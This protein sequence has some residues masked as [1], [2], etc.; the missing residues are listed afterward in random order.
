VKSLTKVAVLL[1][2]VVLPASADT[3]AGRFNM[4]FGAAVVGLGEIDWTPA[5]NP[6]LDLVP[7]FGAFTMNPLSGR[8][9]VFLD[10]VLNTLP[11]GG[12]IGDL[13]QNPLDANYVPVGVPIIRPNFITLAEKPTLNFILDLLFPGDIIGGSPSAFV[14]A[15]SGPNVSATISL[16]GTALDIGSG[17]PITVWTASISTQYNNTTVPDLIAFALAGG[18]LPDNAWS[19]TLD[20]VPEP[21]SLAL[22]LGLGLGAICIQG[23]RLKASRGRPQ[24]EKV[25]L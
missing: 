2:S 11:N 22:M 25:A 4:T 6:G 10:P 15:Q 20:A 24:G 19:G 1:A 18:T 17:D 5:L 12:T 9:G 7:T 16:H 13:S 21:T 14:L 23:R 8:T 3:I